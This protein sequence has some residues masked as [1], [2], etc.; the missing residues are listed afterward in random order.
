MA[1]LTHPLWN[2]C[3]GDIIY[4]TKLEQKRVEERISSSSSTE[5]NRSSE[6]S[7]E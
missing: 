3:V 7:S 1:R 6:S 5:T 4:N 2:M